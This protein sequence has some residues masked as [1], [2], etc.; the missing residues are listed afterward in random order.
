MGSRRTLLAAFAITGLLA[1]PVRADEP[2]DDLGLPTPESAAEA[3]PEATEAA[4]ASAEPGPSAYPDDSGIDPIAR[5]G[6]V[7]GV[8]TTAADLLVMRPVGFVSLFAGGAAFILTS[9]IRAAIGTLD[10]GVDTLRDRADDVFTRPLG[11]I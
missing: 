9:P 4:T 3:A 6:G 2:A 10:D 1:A 7:G 11:G 5:P 8:A